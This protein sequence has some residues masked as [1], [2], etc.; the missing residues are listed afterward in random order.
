MSGTVSYCS[1]PVPGPVPGVTLTLTGNT[2]GSTSSDGSGNY[3]FSALPSGGSFTVTPT[4]ADRAPGSPGINTVDVV[5]VQRHFLNIT[6]IPPGC[7]LT[8]ADVNLDTL[9]TT[10][11]VIAI[12]RF[13]IGLSSGIANA[14]N[15]PVQSCELHLSG[16]NQ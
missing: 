16:D 10:T 5:A 14:G 13:A 12:Q 8:A 3:S 11:D 2:A 7:A 1:N 15:V 4:K 6:L 9:I